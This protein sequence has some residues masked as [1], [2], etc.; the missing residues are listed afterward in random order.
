[1]LFAIHVSGQQ[2]SRLTVSIGNR[3]VRC[4]RFADLQTAAATISQLSNPLVMVPFSWLSQRLKGTA[5]SP[6]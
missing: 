4:G 3:V 6:Y 5:E 1:M 2:V